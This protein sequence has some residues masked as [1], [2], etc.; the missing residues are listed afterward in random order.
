MPILSE[1]SII[2]LND[3][4]ETHSQK[5]HCMNSWWGTNLECWR[6]QADTQ[7]ELEMLEKRDGLQAISTGSRPW[8]HPAG[9][10]L[11]ARETSLENRTQGL[12]P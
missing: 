11:V 10:H 8:A 12:W 2:S 1:V 3:G 5:V 6:G 4:P 9:Q 7:R